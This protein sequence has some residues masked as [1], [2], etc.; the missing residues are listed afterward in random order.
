[1]NPAKS[2]RREETSGPATEYVLRLRQAYGA[3]AR[4]ADETRRIVDASMRQVSLT[5]VLY[6]SRKD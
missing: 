6:E 5:D 4:P 3:Y 1:M 2:V